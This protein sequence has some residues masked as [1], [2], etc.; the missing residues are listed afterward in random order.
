MP[1]KRP[2]EPRRCASC[3]K[4]RTSASPSTIC[5]P[6]AHWVT[7]EIEIRR[8]DTRF[9]LARMPEGQ[10]PKHDEGETTALEWL[11]PTRSDRALRAPR[12]AAA[13]ADVHHHPPAGASRRRSTMCWR[14]RSRDGSRA[15]CRASSRTATSDADAAGRSAVSDDSGLGRARGNAVRAAGWSAMATAR[16]PDRRRSISVIGYFNARRLDLPDGFFDR[17]TQ[18][19]I[20]GAPFETLL[21][22]AAERS[23][24]PDAGARPGRVSVQ[25]QGAAAR[26]AGRQ[27]RTRRGRHGWRPVKIA[28][29]RVARRELCVA[30]A[31]R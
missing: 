22:A 12:A 18:F 13:A 31:R 24:D 8:Y 9:F 4:R 27:A 29:E 5:M 1:R 28:I 10:T 26:D 14:G 15:S 25:R 7:P 20:N 6:F 16:K 11:S 19:V 21:S 17:R 23:A 2:I 30:P 3:R